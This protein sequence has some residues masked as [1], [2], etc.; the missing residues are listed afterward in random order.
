[1]H[2]IITGMMSLMKE[3]PRPSGSVAGR[4]QVG[5]RHGIAS[6]MEQFLGVVFTPIQILLSS[7]SPARLSAIGFVWRFSRPLWIRLIFP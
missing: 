1:M 5:Q 3:R 4:P 7:V 2:E 6:H